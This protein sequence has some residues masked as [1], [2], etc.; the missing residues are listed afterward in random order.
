MFRW[1]EDVNVSSKARCT[2]PEK[3]TDLGK[4]VGPLSVARTVGPLEP[5]E[6][7]QVEVTVQVKKSPKPEIHLLECPC[8]RFITH[9]F[10]NF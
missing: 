4:V 7:P 9:S 8:E 10:V 6:F 5:P 2:N 3:L 1:R